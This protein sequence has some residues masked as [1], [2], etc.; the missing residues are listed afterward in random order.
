MQT[1]PQL[2]GKRAGTYPHFAGNPS[3]TSRREPGQIFGGFERGSSKICGTQ[4]QANHREPDTC[5]QVQ[6]STG[7]SCGIWT[8]TKP[9]RGAYNTEDDADGGAGGCGAGRNVHVLSFTRFFASLRGFASVCT[10][11]EIGQACFDQTCRCPGQG[12]L[13]TL[14]R[15]HQGCV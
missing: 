7:L 3:P 1:R 15:S 5:N 13:T 2:T 4:T 6:S 8:K 12:P 14:D 10:R 9:R 11:R